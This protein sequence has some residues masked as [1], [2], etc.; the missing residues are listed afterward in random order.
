M[1]LILLMVALVQINGF[2]NEPLL[3]AKL[4]ELEN[5]AQ[6]NANQLSES[7]FQDVFGLISQIETVLKSS[8][9][10]QQGSCV[11]A[12]Y[13]INTL[14]LDESIEL[15]SNGGS[16]ETVNC[17]RES[18][19]KNSMRKEESIRL[20]SNRGNLQTAECYKQSY[21]K[22]SLPKDQ[23]ILLCENRGTQLTADCYH[24]GRYYEYLTTDQ[25]LKLCFKSGTIGRIDCYKDA[26]RSL[27]KEQALAL[28]SPQ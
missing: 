14:T 3:M 7:Q 18:Y 9:H 12:A 24:Q 16:L 5:L 15:C 1:K 27:S 4:N 26:R 22:N 11:N 6:Q 21:F 25:A 13:Q 2:A 19:F 28:C 8:G 17:Y 10:N 20:C 23:A